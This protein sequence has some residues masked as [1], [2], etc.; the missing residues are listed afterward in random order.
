[1]LEKHF[2]NCLRYAKSNVYFKVT[3]ISQILS[4]E[5]A[6]DGPGISEDTPLYFR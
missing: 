4:F 5:I 2:R 1:M 3:S 6:D